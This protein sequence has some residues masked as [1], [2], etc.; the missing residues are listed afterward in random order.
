MGNP[1]DQPK[2]AYDFWDCSLKGQPDYELTDENGNYLHHTD[3]VGQ[4][5]S[6][7]LAQIKNDQRPFCLSVS[8]KAPHVQDNDPRQFIID[9]RYN[10]YYSDVTIPVPETAEAK[11]WEQFP[12][13][14][15]TDEN[16]GRERWKSSFQAEIAKLRGRYEELKEKA[17]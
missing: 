8:F 17:Q 9:P 11:Y 6:R 15:R 1:K 5:F 2:D 10:S 14:F 13:F 3:K 12:E 16:I 7:F 4:N